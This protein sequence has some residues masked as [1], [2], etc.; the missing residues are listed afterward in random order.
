MGDY[1]KRNSQTEQRNVII[2]KHVEKEPSQQIDVK[3]LANAVAQTILS[4]LPKNQGQTFIMSNN[5]EVKDT[6]NDKSS[7][8]RLAESMI[9]QRGNNVSNFNELGN[10]Q[11]T[12]KNQ[13]ETDKTIDLLK[14]LED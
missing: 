11:E 7:L 5:G 2:E 4:Q 1:V 8:E 12:Q 3:A 14:G 13:S 10:I 6:F 9:I